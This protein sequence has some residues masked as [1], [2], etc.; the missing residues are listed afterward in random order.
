MKFSLSYALPINYY[1]YTPFTILYCENNIG[2][3]EE[4]NELWTLL[5]EEKNKFFLALV[6]C[7]NNDSNTYTFTT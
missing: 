1:L 3:L 7:D 2:L 5:S 6:S 4:T